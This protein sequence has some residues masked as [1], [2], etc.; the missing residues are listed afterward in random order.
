MGHSTGG[1]KKF[2]SPQSI[3]GTGRDGSWM[4]EATR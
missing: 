2:T 1:L 4:D 3:F